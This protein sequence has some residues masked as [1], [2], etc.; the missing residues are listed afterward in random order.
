[1]T[2][3]KNWNIYGLH[4]FINILYNFHLEVPYS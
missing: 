2:N 1:M 3:F 4:H